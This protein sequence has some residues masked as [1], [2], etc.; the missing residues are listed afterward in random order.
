[1]TAID[2]LGKEV[3]LG[4]QYGYSTK[5]HVVV[6]TAEKVNKSTVSIRVKIS[7]KYLYG[8]PSDSGW[9][10]HAR[11]VAVY[12]FHLFPVQDTEEDKS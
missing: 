9:G 5:N 11:V 8:E 10:T 4:S 2:A 6:G 7:Q 1:M 12:P 3:V